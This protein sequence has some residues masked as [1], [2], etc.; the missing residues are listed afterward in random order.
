MLLLKQ[1]AAVVNIITCGIQVFLYEDNKV[2]PS[3]VV[4]RN[5]NNIWKSRNNTIIT[6]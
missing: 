5:M 1:N 2:A 3:T 6:I 4:G